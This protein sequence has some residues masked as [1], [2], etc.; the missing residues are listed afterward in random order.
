MT[1][2]NK[3]LAELLNEAIEIYKDIQ[4]NPE[5]N[6]EVFY[7]NASVTGFNMR[8]DLADNK[9]AQGAKESVMGD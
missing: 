7:A 4:K 9:N 5:G 1:E 3:K 8:K 6:L 2:R